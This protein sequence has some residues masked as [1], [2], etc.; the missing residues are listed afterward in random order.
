M[1]QMLLKGDSL[2]IIR[3]CQ[4]V[5][6]VCNKYHGGWMSGLTLREMQQERV[7]GETQN[8]SLQVLNAHV[9]GELCMFHHCE[10]LIPD[11][12]QRDFN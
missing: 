5:P 6:C 4:L 11:V 3:A 2:A 1:D 10:P 9:C 12:M 8:L 7:W